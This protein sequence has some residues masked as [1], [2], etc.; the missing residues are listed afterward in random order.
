MKAVRAAKS[1]TPLVGS[2]NS[3]LHH[4]GGHIFSYGVRGKIV[5]RLGFDVLT[6]KLGGK[7]SNLARRIETA[8]RAA[9]KEIAKR[10]KLTF[11]HVHGVRQKL[12][13][14][15]LDLALL[16]AGFKDAPKAATKSPGGSKF[17]YD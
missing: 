7:P 14:S 4:S 2:I 6:S 17:H 15:G 10:L 1:G 3:P 13:S 12:R 16:T 11:D 9:S 8:D 5:D